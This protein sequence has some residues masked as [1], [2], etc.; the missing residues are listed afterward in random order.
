MHDERPRVAAYLD[1]ELSGEEIAEIEKIC[2]ESDVHL[3]E[4]AARV[5][6]LYR[7]AG[8]HLSR[9]IVPPQELKNGRIR[10][11]VIEGRITEL[12]LKGDGAEQFGLRPLLEPVLADDPSRLATL[13]RQLLLINGR[14]GVRIAD[15]TL[16]E[17]GEAKGIFVWLSR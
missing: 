9:A 1:N 12:A 4:I 15:T 7:D 13:E 3:A 11:K 5:S 16:E 10:L 14:A 8:Y 2:L 17:I 6:D